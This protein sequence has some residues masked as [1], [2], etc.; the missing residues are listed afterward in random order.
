MRAVASSGPEAI[1]RLPANEHGGEHEG[2]FDAE[3]QLRVGYP[4]SALL[5]FATPETRKLRHAKQLQLD[6]SLIAW[7]DEHVQ[8]GDV[9]Y[10]IGAGIGECALVAAVHRGALV[11]AIEPGFAA[12]KRLC[13]NILLNNCRRSVVPLPAAIAERTGLLELEYAPDAAGE[14]RH[15]VRPRTWRTRNEGI[16]PF[17]VQP[18]CADPLDDVIKRY[19][20]P[21]PNHIRIKAE[22]AVER[23]LA[24][25]SAT[26]RDAALRSLLVPGER[27]GDT[28]EW[29]VRRPGTLTR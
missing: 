14:D 20:L 16:E 4:H 11:V 5:V 21:R 23:V 24:G 18:V 3:K 17:Y 2:V 7:L 13:D 1:T 19:A 27:R 15:H 28:R 22:T 26:L 9:V 29:I 8:P 25:A 6:P 10:D 12:F